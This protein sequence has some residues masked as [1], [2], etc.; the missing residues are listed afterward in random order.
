[1]EVSNLSLK[2]FLDLFD[3][4]VA[5]LNNENFM[6]GLSTFIN[7]DHRFLDSEYCWNILDEL[8]VGLPFSRWSS[9]ANSNVFRVYLC[10]FRFFWV[11]LCFDYEHEPFSILLYALPV[12]LLFPLFFILLFPLPFMLFHLLYYY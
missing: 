10:Y 6:A 3:I 12:L 11:W 1:M 2:S 9:Y 5:F 4:K 7:V 8:Y